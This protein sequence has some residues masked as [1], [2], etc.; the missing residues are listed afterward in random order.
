MFKTANAEGS[1]RQYRKDIQ[2]QNQTLRGIEDRIT[3]SRQMSHLLSTFLKK[4][5]RELKDMEAT[6]EMLSNM[7]KGSLFKLEHEEKL[8]ADDDRNQV[9]TAAQVR[10]SIFV[11]NFV[12]AYL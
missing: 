7:R 1:I 10:M 11:C 3:E 5:S 2:D 9:Q 8:F 6:T 12:S 4:C